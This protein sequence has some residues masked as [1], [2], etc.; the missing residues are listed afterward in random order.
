MPANE[1]L[2]CKYNIGRILHLKMTKWLK[3]FHNQP[4]LYFNLGEK[5]T[6]LER[7][8]LNNYVMRLALQQW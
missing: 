5:S 7:E 8:Q 2:T 1:R 3:V 6:A 4:A